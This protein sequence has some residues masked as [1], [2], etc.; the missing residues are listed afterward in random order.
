[1][2]APDVCFTQV[3]LA[4]LLPAATLATLRRINASAEFYIAPPRWGAPPTD[5]F[6]PFAAP[7]VEVRRRAATSREQMR[8]I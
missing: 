4:P 8:S 2:G 6:R 1:M 5:A 7:L 3:N